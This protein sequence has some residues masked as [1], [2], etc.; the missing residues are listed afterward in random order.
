MILLAVL[1][2]LAASLLLYVLF[3]GA[4][5]GAGVLELFLSRKSG[6]AERKLISEAMAPVWEANHVWLILALVIVFV[7][8]PPLY[9]LISIYLHLPVLL[10]LIG[11]VARGCAFTFRH[12]DTLT[13]EFQPLYNWT[14]ALSSLWTSF[15]LGV[16]GGALI[17]GRI[18][19]TATTFAELYLAPWANW[20]CLAM[21][22][23]TTS[24]FAFLAA[25]Y[26]VGEANTPSL[27]QSF[28]RKA[29]ASSIAML[30]SGVLV[31]FTSELEGRP[32]FREFFTHPWSVACFCLATL[33]FYPLFR[34][35]KQSVLWSRALGASIVA[36]VLLG[37]Y[38]IQLPAAVLLKSGPITF[39]E[40]AAPQATL[41][42]L[43]WALAIGSILIFP[44][45]AYLLKIF[46]GAR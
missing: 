32:L 4:D 36:L 23:F 19:P 11:I 7:G 33:L 42:A 40:A 37:W 21:G 3:G 20:F 46:K 45:L 18:D 39:F 26:L 16:T 2:F 8:F 44:A 10:V 17:L 14:F 27:Q 15:F 43:L 31:F 22:L 34:S 28:W 25:V 41:S 9:S 35:L 24:L 29:R 6:S 13:P 38:A 12:Y 30:A 1:G 5:F